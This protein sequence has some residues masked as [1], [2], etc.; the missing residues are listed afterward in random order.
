MPVAICCALLPAQ[1]QAWMLQVT[2]VDNVYIDPNNNYAET[3]R[4]RVRALTSSG[5]VDTTVN[6]SVYVQEAD[7][8]VYDGLYGASA[9][10]LEL[11][12]RDGAAQLTLRSL[13]RYT[14]I[15]QRNDPVPRIDIAADESSVSFYVPQW[16]DADHDGEIDW[17][18]LRVAALVRRGLESNVPVV[19]AVL[20]SVQ[21]W[22][23]SSAQDCGGV[24]PQSPTTVQVGAVCLNAEGMNTHRTNMDAELATTLLHEAR[25]VWNFRYPDRLRLPQVYSAGHEPPIARAS[26]CGNAESQVCKNDPHLNLEAVRAHEFD[27]EQFAHRYKHVLQ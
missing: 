27:A 13:A 3:R 10:P 9:L 8:Q 21:D 17:L 4:Y 20:A 19:R 25:H 23:Q 24:L 5:E 15:E 1:A 12:M 2:P 16:V 7:T 22:R 14:A 18:A 26:V 11:E 6:T